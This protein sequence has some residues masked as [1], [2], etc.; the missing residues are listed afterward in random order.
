MMG[1][2]KRRAIVSAILWT[3]AATIAPVGFRL[4]SLGHWLPEA[5][6]MLGGWEGTQSTLD[7]GARSRIGNSPVHSMVY[8]S[9]LGEAATVQF[10]AATSF[11]AFDDPLEF[12]GQYE[13]VAERDIALGNA[14]R[15]VRAS[16]YRSRSNPDI[17][18]VSYTWW[19]SR[20]GTVHSLRAGSRDKMRRRFVSAYRAVMRGDGCV[21]RLITSV[22]PEDTTGART[23]R[24][25]DRLA[26]MVVGALG[27]HRGG[28]GA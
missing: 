15:I 16:A 7:V 4:A 1:P 28:D 20:S 25:M 14:S 17:R 13:I 10:V 3:G 12:G 9:P 5:P 2:G 8:R 27:S 23:R 11:Q 19:Q 24:T 21:V 18:L 6:A 22:D 26:R